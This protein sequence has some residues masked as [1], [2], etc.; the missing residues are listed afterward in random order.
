MKID[1]GVHTRASRKPQDTDPF[2]RDV[3]VNPIFDVYRAHV[4][5]TRL[6]VYLRILY[7]TSSPV[8]LLFFLFPRH[9][10]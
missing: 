8:F 9:N 7:T 5:T 10:R 4:Y 1:C 3:V 6:V 2:D